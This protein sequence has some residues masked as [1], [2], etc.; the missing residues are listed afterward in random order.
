MT[1]VH[2]TN[3]LRTITGDIQE[4]TDMQ[5]QP[6]NILVRYH[7]FQFLCMHKTFE[8]MLTEKPHITGHET[9]VPYIE[10]T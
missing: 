10:R 4:K 8:R 3:E 2:L 7:M 6:T 9:N 1:P 5:G